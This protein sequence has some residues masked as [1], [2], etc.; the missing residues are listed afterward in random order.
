MPYLST[1]GPIVNAS[2]ENVIPE[3]APGFAYSAP[4]LIRKL[5]IGDDFV[6]KSISGSFYTDSSEG[7]ILFIS[8]Y[9]QGPDDG[10]TNAA[11][12]NGYGV[13]IRVGNGAQ[14]AP[15]N[16]FIVHNSLG[17]RQVVI[18][19]VIH[20]GW[21]D[22]GYLAS[23]SMLI[24]AYKTYNFE[25]IYLDGGALDVYIWE[26]TKPLIPTISYGAFDH[27]SM[28]SYYGVSVSNTQGDKWMI[29][30]FALSNTS[31][32]YAMHLSRLDASYLGS[33]FTVSAFAFAVGYTGTIDN[34]GITMYCFN[35][36]TGVW[37]EV[38]NHDNPT[39]SGDIRLNS[40]ELLL[41]Q[42]GSTSLPQSVDALLV[43]K[44]PSNY[45]NGIDSYIYVDYVKAESW[46]DEYSHVGGKGDIYIRDTAS[47]TEEYMDVLNCGEKEILIPSNAKIINEFPLPILWISQVELLDF[48]G[49]PTGSYLVQN[50]DW[51]Y[52][53]ITPSMRFSPKE[54]I[55]LILAS[56]GWNIRVHYSTFTNISSI[57]DYCDSIAHRNV[58][59]D[60]LVKTKH[61]IELFISLSVIGTESP[62]NIR[63]YLSDWIK[64]YEETTIS[65]SDIATYL[66]SYAAIND[67]T[68]NSVTY[69]E[70][71]TDGSYDD[72]PLLPSETLQLSSIQMFI[73]VPDTEHISITVG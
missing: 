48:A 45:L 13:A 72:E 60:L 16:V 23:T 39:G 73:I 7:S 32:N 51:T 3:P 31:A 54:E 61:P 4:T 20:T 38:D 44:Y 64:T 59:D 29:D 25:L 66:Q 68:V 53:C 21:G 71:L 56:P 27:Q 70:H 5:E 2:P 30:N 47:L 12:Y 19:K 43:S 52:E 17:A 34:A 26:V 40:G 15:S 67:V 69:R 35:H 33:K 18:E 24:E 11:F 49:N 55:L 22:Y 1:S 63:T 9:R 36:A 8:A 57:Q 58:T 28:G 6:N 62:F 65:Y 10:F 41:S 42:Y 37:D 14:N 46:N 50:S